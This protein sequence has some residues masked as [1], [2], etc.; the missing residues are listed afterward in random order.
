MEDRD[1]LC[2][3]GDGVR[4]LKIYQGSFTESFIKIHHQ[5]ACQDYTYHQSLLLAS[6]RTCNLEVPDGTG[7]GVGWSSI[8]IGTFP[9]GLMMMMV[10]A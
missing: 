1:V 3:T 9:E 4:V 8:P 7:F 5:E 10:P 2:G 6:W